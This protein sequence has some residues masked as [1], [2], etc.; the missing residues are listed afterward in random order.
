MDIEDMT[1]EGLK[2]VQEIQEKK[3]KNVNV[4]KSK[5]Y[6]VMGRKHYKINEEYRTSLIKEENKKCD[7]ECSKIYDEINKERF[8]AGLPEV[9]DPYKERM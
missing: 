9:E 6:K 5:S 2:K 4:I 3:K 8:K 1:L 7:K